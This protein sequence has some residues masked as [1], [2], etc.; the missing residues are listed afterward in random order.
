MIIEEKQIRVAKSYEIAL[1]EDGLD[2][3]DSYDFGLNAG[4]NAIFDN[5]SGYQCANLMKK[6]VE[7]D[8]GKHVPEHITY[9]IVDHFKRAC[10]R[11]AEQTAYLKK[12]KE[13]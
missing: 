4:L 3:D 13:K 11:I 10:G 9:E 12:V 8:L 2:I 5:L 1:K 7:N 6:L